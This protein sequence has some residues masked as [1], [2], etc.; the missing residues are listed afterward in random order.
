MGSSISTPVEIAAAAPA[1][2]LNPALQRL[3]KQDAAGPKALTP[4][5]KTE[6]REALSDA[7]REGAALD[8][9]MASIKASGVMTTKRIGIVGG[10]VAA[11]DS[12]YNSFANLGNMENSG[13]QRVGTPV[14]KALATT[15]SI[16]AAKDGSSVR[17]EVT[18]LSKASVSAEAAA[19]FDAF[20]VVCAKNAAASKIVR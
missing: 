2:P 17:V 14:K 7:L 4:R 1:T 5:T 18:N 11:V 6:L 3:K 8:E 9:V 20:V 12:F 10:D 13:P 15:P 19:G 16:V